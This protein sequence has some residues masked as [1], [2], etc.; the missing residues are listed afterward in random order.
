MAKQKFKHKKKEESVVEEVVSTPKPIEGPRANIKIHAI[1]LFVLAFIVYGNTFNNKWALDDTL[2]ILG[3]SFTKQGVGGLKG[4][5]TKDMFVGAHGR[6]FELTGGRY[7]PLS[8]TVFA[9]QVEFFGKDFEKNPGVKDRLAFVGHFTNVLFF[10]LSGIFIYLML[11]KLFRSYNEWI[12]LITTAIFVVHP[13]HTEVVANI[14][15]LDEILALMFFV[16]SFY[17]LLDNDKKGII[18][19]SLFYMLALLSKENTIT[20]L[21]IIPL[22]FIL[23]KKDSIA[24]GFKKVL[25]LVGV[26]AIYLILRENF[27][28]GFSSGLA[29]KN[30]MDNP[31]LGMNIGTKTATLFLIAGKYLS[32]LFVPI[33]LSYDYS[34]N[35]IGW[36]QWNDPMVLLS[37]VAI[38]GVAI[39]SVK[40]LIAYLKNQK[41]PSIL[42][43]GLWFYIM[44]YSIVSNFVF[45]IGTYMGERF[46]YMASLGFCLS[47]AALLAQAL[48][49]GLRNEVNFNPSWLIPVLVIL[50]PFSAM[51]IDRN[52]DW[53]D[54][55][56]LYKTDIER[57]PN[58]ARARLFIG[59]E[60]LNHFYRDKDTL[61]LNSSIEQMT[62]AT[63]IYPDFYHAYYNLGLAYQAKQDHKKAIEVFQKVLAIQP[64]HINTHYYLGMS[65]GT[66]FHDAK[67]AIEYMERGI[68]YGY[69][70]ADRYINLGVAYGINGNLQ[71]AA[72]SFEKA[73]PE[74]QNNPQ[75]YKNLAIT[76]MNLRN[77][78]KADYY[79]NL[80]Q[81]FQQ[82]AAK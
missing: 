24:Q 78:Q 40:E 31:F 56:T 70:G 3:N 57:V 53:A 72:E 76:Y 9:L 74:N 19:G 12:P 13:I 81:Q 32:L 36:R 79:Q 4:I 26:A 16:L 47:L 35:T 75:L 67:K 5:W 54:N 23:F 25:P 43:Y 77:K 33:D 38:L 46:I 71:K 37:F 50:I 82:Q 59:I 14:K 62:K 29:A 55:Y 39:Y 61:M 49:I 42:V 8:L 17:K 64:T 18:Y 65:Y 80:A 41:E 63:E 11:L 1:F 10:A 6:E 45:N 7:R 66:G 73:I 22:G 21:G 58:S 27:S 34:Y 60:D 69:N 28:G 20:A 15:S 2:V 52:E 48:K 30:L 44:S 51:T 68:Q